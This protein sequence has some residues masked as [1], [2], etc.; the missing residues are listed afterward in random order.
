MK[1]SEHFDLGEFTRSDYAKRNGIKNMPNPEQTDNLRELCVNV[2]EPIRKHFQ[3]PILISSGFRS[4]ELNN[5]I[6][7]AKNSQHVSGEAVDIDHDLSA[8]VVS[9]RMI[10]DFIKS[11]L[12]FDQMI[13]E[14]GTSTNPDW[15]HVSYVGNGK[16]RNQILRAIKHGGKTIYEKY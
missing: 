14:F 6:G 8:N 13:W 4:K 1:L 5:A 2:L 16:N 10:F 3:I 11:N 9:N 7:G 15:V 12:T